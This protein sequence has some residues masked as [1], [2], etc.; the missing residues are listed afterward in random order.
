MCERVGVCRYDYHSAVA[1]KAFGSCVYECMSA[2]EGMKNVH[3]RINKSHA[4]L[5]VS[6]ERIIDRLQRNRRVLVCV[7]VSVQSDSG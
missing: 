5:R 4:C 1:C 6:G 3:L 7:R 2:G